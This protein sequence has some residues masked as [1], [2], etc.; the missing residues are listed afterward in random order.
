MASKVSIAIRQ[1][2]AVANLNEA[3]ASLGVR[4]GVEA[5]NLAPTH[6]DPDIERAEQLEALAE[7]LVK[8][9]AAST[10][11]PVASL[12]HPEEDTSQTWA[13]DSASLGQHESPEVKPP[14]PSKRTA[15]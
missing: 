5:G 9:E 12:G 3:A 13:W 1:D 7:F 6:K 4:F 14:T 15:K 11:A 10:P 8:L 2:E